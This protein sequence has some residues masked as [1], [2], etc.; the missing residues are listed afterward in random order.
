LATRPSRS[1]DD[2]LIAF[3][4]TA[5]A[6][7]AHV[8]HRQLRYWADTELVGPSIVAQVGA[9]TKPRL[10]AFDDLLALLVAA[11]LRE[12]F[13]L[14]HVRR[15]VHYLSRKGYRRPLSELR[16]A[17]EGDQ[18]FFQHADGTWEGDRRPGQVVL[19]HVIEL[20]LLRRRIR[21]AAAAPR[22][23]ALKGATERRRKVHGSKPVFSGTRTPVEALFP[24]LERRYTTDKILAAFP[25][26]SREDV[27]LARR[28]FRE[29]G[30]A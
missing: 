23:R 6:R 25:H 21:E 2:S 5:A 24:Y 15:V 11:Q 30:A 14:Q 1:A 29:S 7:M 26:L 16:F 19:T 17:I 3:T 28:Q 12:R 4:E 10:Y 27:S 20:D 13:S 9:R 8:S 22:E 18:I